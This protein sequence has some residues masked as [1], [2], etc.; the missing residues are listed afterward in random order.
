MA[1]FKALADLAL[2]A[3]LVDLADFEV[4]ADSQVCQVCQECLGRLGRL[5]IQTSLLSQTWQNNKLVSLGRL[6]SLATPCSLADFATAAL[7]DFQVYEAKL[8][9]LGRLRRLPSQ[10]SLQVC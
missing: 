5:R 8:D 10:P 4:S 7:A 1:E 3:V 2:M 9:R 6:R